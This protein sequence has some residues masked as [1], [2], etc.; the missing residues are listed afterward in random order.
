MVVFMIVGKNEPIFEMEVARAT[1]DAQ[2]DELAYLHQ[3]IL[4]SSLDLINSAMWTNN[5]I[6]L[7]TVDK[8]NFLLVS[9]YV[10]MGGKY[11]LLLHNGK[12]EDAVRAFF[13]EVHELYVKYLINPFAEPDA[14]VVS[15]QFSAH[16]RSLAKRLIA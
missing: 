5:A 12:N 15:P 6:F 3:F 11:F 4:Y 7:R 10:T 13:T 14:P 2:N 1:G 8:F 16:V 9:A